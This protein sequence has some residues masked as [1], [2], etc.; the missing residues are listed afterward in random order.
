[1]DTQ[2]DQAATTAPQEPGTH[3]FAITLEVP[4]YASFT[5]TGSYTPA[6]GTTREQAFTRIYAH[7]IDSSGDPRMRT[8]NVLFFSLEPNEL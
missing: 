2:T 8:A 3:F 6:P 7:A 5:T 1:M 4:T